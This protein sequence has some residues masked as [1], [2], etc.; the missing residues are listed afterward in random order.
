MWSIGTPNLAIARFCIHPCSFSFSCV[1]NLEDSRF[2][3]ICVNR[4]YFLLS[5]LYTFLPHRKSNQSWAACYTGSTNKVLMRQLV[6]SFR[7]RCTLE[8]LCNMWNSQPHI[9]NDNLV[10][11]NCRFHAP[12]C[13]LF[14]KSAY[15]LGLSAD[16]NIFRALAFNLDAKKW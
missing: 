5:E 12:I 13:L 6:F 15:I 2:P 7:H 8:W 14:F 3:D 11:Y 16:K 9:M 10:L 1:G 4:P